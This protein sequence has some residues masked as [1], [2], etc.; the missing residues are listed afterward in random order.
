MVYVG[1]YFKGEFRLRTRTAQVVHIVSRIYFAGN[2]LDAIVILI[3]FLP[4]CPQ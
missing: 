3:A 2:H 4:L 1:V